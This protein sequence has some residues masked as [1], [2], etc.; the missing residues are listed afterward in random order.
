M[1]HAG[2]G[3]PVATSRRTWP[4]AAARSRARSAGLA[5][6]DVLAGDRVELAQ[7][8]AVGAGA[9]V[10]AGDVAVAGARRR[11]KGDDRTQVVV[12]GQGGSS[13]SRGHEFS[14]LQ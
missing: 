6:V 10:L 4:L 9:T 7:D 5:E 11:A 13:G 8:E 1:R 12:L 3:M 14:R 2:H